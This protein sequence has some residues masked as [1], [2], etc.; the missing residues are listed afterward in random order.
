MEEWWYPEILETVEIP[1]FKKSRIDGLWAGEQKETIQ[2]Y[3]ED[4]K[5]EN[6]QQLCKTM[7]AL[8]Y[9]DSTFVGEMFQLFPS[10]VLNSADV[11]MDV[12]LNS[13]MKT[14]EEIYQYVELYRLHLL[15][16]LLSGVF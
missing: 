11:D 8:L 1:I 7:Y 9:P 2:C 15:Q 16:W 5:E 10:S 12:L 4:A 14:A 3:Q 6:G 13:D